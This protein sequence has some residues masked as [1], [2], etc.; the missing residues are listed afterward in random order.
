M[1]SLHIQSEIHLIASQ[2]SNDCMFSR[3][4][5][6]FLLYIFLAVPRHP[7]PEAS[8][9]GVREAA[10]TPRPGESLRLP[11]DDDSQGRARSHVLKK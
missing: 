6:S 2:S 1:Q 3:V 10:I 4:G 11:V 9:G 5:K 7:H 8:Q